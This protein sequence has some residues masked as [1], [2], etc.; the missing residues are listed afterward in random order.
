MTYV[1]NLAS[2]AIAIGLLINLPA[3]AGSPVAAAESGARLGPEL[4]ALHA[5]FL[6]SGAGGA[7][8]LA[9]QRRISLDQDRVQVV[10]EFPEGGPVDEAAATA[11]G[12][13]IELRY[14][15]LVR[16]W[17]PF[18]RLEAVAS[19]VPALV[20]MRLPFRPQPLMESQ[21][22][23]ITGASDFQA[24]GFDGSG[25]KV[26]IIDLGFINLSNAQAQGELPAGVIAVDFTGTGIEST[27]KH[28]T[29]V[30]EVVHDMA[31]G[32]QL[33]LLKI[34]DDV[35]LGAAKEYCIDNGIQVINH[36]VAWF[37]A[38]FYDGTGIIDQIADD[39]YAHGILWVNATGNYARTHYQSILR[40]DDNDTLHE[41]ATEDEAMSFSVA[42]GTTI[43][44][45]LNWDAYP[46]TSDDYDLFLYDVDP[47]LNAGAVPVA[48]SENTQGPGGSAWYPVE[49][50]I[51][52]VPTTGPYYLVIKKKTKQDTNRAIEVF[53]TG[54]SNA[55]LEYNTASTSVPHPADAAGVLAV[56]AVNRSDSLE[57][58]S[59][60]GPTNDGRT[61]PDVTAPD[62]VANYTYGSFR[63]TSASSPHVAGAA[64]L[65]L[66]QS[67]SLTVQALWDIL[68]TDT[69]ELGA[70]GK[71]DLYGSGRISLDADGDGV[72][73]DVDNCPLT[74][75][76]SQVDGDGDQ[77]GDAC[78]NCPAD[79]NAS[80]LDTDGDGVGDACDQCPGFDD[81]ADADGDTAPDAC[82]N[83]VNVANSSQ[84]DTDGDGM[85]DA[86]D[87]DDDDDGLSDA[88]E[89]ALY[90]TNP[91]LF[92]TDGDTYG[93]GDEVAAGS[94]PLNPLS[95]PQS[96]S[97]D[98]AP[99]GAPDGTVN[100]ADLLVLLRL[101]EGLG[102]PP[103][104]YELA[105]G[106]LTG[107][108]ML[109]LRDVLALMTAL[110]F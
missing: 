54:V 100:T 23:G 40:D 14:R 108:D 97:G 86:C 50:L 38:A 78:D 42:P 21:G 28:G 49:Y 75:N 58:F 99:R 8:A 30:A 103:T 94:D 47:D 39:A 46:V 60:R 19:G 84:L 88:D 59:S 10:L 3:W 9:R 71:D 12:A 2:V 109:D 20:R 95:V 43:Q 41:F 73:H 56:G 87:S 61:K 52:T 72:I 89:V 26:A 70:A 85:G 77:V 90:G 65:L 17:V 16:A 102:D 15:H 96:A 33:F 27:L 80:Q 13:E 93:D 7:S 107:D 57:S 98:V 24:L 62:D 35:A 36:S 29:G 105:A 45:Y 104:P 79:A 1:T 76:L 110:G 91:L 83:C 25:V 51:Y 18:A 44:F 48:S 55:F 67:P 11:L 106:D 63:G 82:D 32:A 101:V 74:A 81:T 69:V 53:I 66:D 37:A 4:A 34:D 5:A 64:A 92:D 6:R 31:P 68:E 22:V